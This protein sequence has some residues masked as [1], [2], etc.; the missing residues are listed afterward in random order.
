MLI[1]IK[2]YRNEKCVIFPRIDLRFA[3]FNAQKTPICVILLTS[4]RH[5][6]NA[7]RQAMGEMT[8]DS[9]RLH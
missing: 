1:F 6:R 9:E 7:R 3:L 5:T 8:Q 2:C 4:K